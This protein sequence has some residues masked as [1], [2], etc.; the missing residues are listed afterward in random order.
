M[1]QKRIFSKEYKIEAVS[2]SSS[3]GNVRQTALSLGIHESVLRRWIREYQLNPSQAF[4]GRGNV[5]IKDAEQQE[6]QAL[7][8]ENK[9]LK[10]EREILK[11]A[12]S[13]FAKND[14]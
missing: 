13:I 5:V 6:L 4:I 12:M 1:S 14:R 7:R 8:K 2:L 9:D 10:M 11:K 3:N